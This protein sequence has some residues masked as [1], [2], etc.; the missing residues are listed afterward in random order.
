MP[1][2]PQ[3][4]PRKP[5]DDRCGEASVALEG[6]WCDIWPW[7]M[8]LTSALAWMRAFTW[9]AVEDLRAGKKDQERMMK[10]IET[11]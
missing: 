1:A 3:I 4:P 8:C 2:C 5:A 9:W 11:F 10:D 7:E 6:Q